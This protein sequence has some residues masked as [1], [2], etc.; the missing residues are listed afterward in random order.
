MERQNKAVLLALVSVLAWS[1]V[2]TGFKLG[3]R[4]LTV[5]QLLWAGSMFACIFFWMVCCK[6]R[7]WAPVPNTRVFSI[8]M[9]LVNPGV[10]YL[11]L[12]A[13]Y[14]RLPAHIAQP[15]NY[16]WALVM[17]FAAWWLLG[18]RPSRGQL[19]ALGLGYLGVLLLVFGSGIDAGGLALDK[20]NYVGAGLAIA[21]TF[22]WAFYW[23][24]LTRTPVSTAPFMAWSFT[25]GLVFISI[26]CLLGDGLPG[27][28]ADT[29]VFGAWVG[30]I[31]MGIT[32]YMWRLA[33]LWATNAVSVAQMI[34]LSPV[35]SLMLIYF[36]LGE[37]IRSLAIVGALI[38]FAS[39]FWSNRLR[40]KSKAEYV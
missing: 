28:D 9:G 30:L 18:Q 13:A 23:V 24:L 14:D 2:A 1:T 39:A 27:F 17:T 8:V 12:F 36:V 4:E 21:S 37:D 38:V 5:S 26:Y 25:S 33:M 35:L 15:L 31:E 40:M 32:F 7:E 11:V 22:L 34:F 3:L 16:S 29:L 10:Y 6:K 20:I 19:M